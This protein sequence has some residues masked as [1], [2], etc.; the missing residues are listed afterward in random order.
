MAVSKI[1]YDGHTLIDLTQ[2][3]ATESDVA[4]G[5]TFHKADGTQA[6][7]IASGGGG[8]INLESKTVNLGS[9]APVTQTPGTGY[10]GIGSVAFNV[11]GIDGTKIK[12]GESI[13]GVSGTYNPQ[14]SFGKAVTITVQNPFPVA[15][16]VYHC[17]YR[18]YDPSNPTSVIWRDL[19]FSITDPG[20]CAYTFTIYIVSD[21]GNTL[22]MSEIE[23]GFYI[24]P[25]DAVTPIYPGGYPTG[26]T[27][28]FHTGDGMYDSSWYF[29][30]WKNTSS[31]TIDFQGI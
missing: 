2:D 21:P 7:G 4:S 30:I 16:D 10:D 20:T 1:A 6:V 5:K 23:D 31:I 18:G 9:A 14:A 29:T 28:R 13:C 27:E 26:Y 8:T 12:N 24:A 11:S 25:P 17:Y 3:T 19:S 15:A 22:P